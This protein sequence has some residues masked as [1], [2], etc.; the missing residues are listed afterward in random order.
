MRDSG[1]TG[2]VAAVDEAEGA[3]VYTVAFDPGL[4]EA[5]G[6]ALPIEPGPATMVPGLP[7]EAF[8]PIA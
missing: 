8:E 7:A 4:D 3:T 1:R 5:T 6:A 2:T